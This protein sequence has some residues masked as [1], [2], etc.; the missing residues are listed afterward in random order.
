MV[1]SSQSST[2][3]SS[4]SV[5]TPEQRQHF[6]V[7]CKDQRKWSLSKDGGCTSSELKA[8]VLLFDVGLQSRLFVLPVL[9]HHG[10]ALVHQLLLSQTNTHIQL[11]YHFSVCAAFQVKH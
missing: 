6:E 10:P 1:S 3:L 2:L 4:S 7:R 8:H 11:P 9:L 5:S